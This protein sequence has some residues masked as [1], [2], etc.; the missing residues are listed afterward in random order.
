[1]NEILFLLLIYALAWLLLAAAG[2]NDLVAWI[3]FLACVG[4]VF[5]VFQLIQAIRTFINRGNAGVPS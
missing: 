5:W 4:F 2:H 1:M 3:V